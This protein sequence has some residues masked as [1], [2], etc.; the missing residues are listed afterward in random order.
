MQS[1]HPQSPQGASAQGAKRAVP[2]PLLLGTRIFNPIVRRFAGR[3][4]LPL[5]AILRHQGRKSG[6]AYSTPVVVQPTDDGF[7]IALAFGKEADWFKNIQAAGGA[8]VVWKGSE[9]ALE[10]PEL[11]DLASALPLFHGRFERAFI[12]RA[13]IKHFARL[14]HVGST[15]AAPA[16]A[17]AAS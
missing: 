7:V 10:D 5:Y 13:G 16:S 12:A 1:T 11:I 4:A 6:R 17:S 8:V 3:R 2:A 15:S 9:Y 14:R